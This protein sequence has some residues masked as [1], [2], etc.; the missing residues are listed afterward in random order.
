MEVLYTT[1]I[2]YIHTSIIFLVIFAFVFVI[3]FIFS[4]IEYYS[5][6]VV[7][8]ILGILAAASIAGIIIVGYNNVKVTVTAVNANTIEANYLQ[9]NHILSQE[10]NILKT[11]SEEDYQKTKK[12]YISTTGE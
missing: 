3:A 1:Q 8:L 10:G 2:T 7:Q 11:I 4:L 6:D 9:D 5:F 12:N